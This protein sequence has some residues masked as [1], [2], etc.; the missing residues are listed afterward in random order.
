MQTII[1][2]IT[3]PV[4]LCDASGRLNPEAK[5]WSRHPY[6]IGN[7]KGRPLRK[8]KWDYWCIIGER[9]AFSATMAH[10]DYGGGGAAYLLDFDTKRFAQHTAFR[11]F[12]SVPVM[13]E[14]VGGTI[15]FEHKGLRLCFEAT[16]DRVHMRVNS[17]SLQGQPL[18][19]D[20]I[21]HRPPEHETLNVLV[22]WNDTTFQ[23][24]SKQ[25]C[26]P[27][28]GEVIWG[29]ERYEFQRETAFGV[30][31]YGRGIWPYRT[32][33]NWGAFSARA[34]QDV[35]GINM[36]AKWTD[37]TGMNENGITVNGV[38][39][40]IFDDLIFDY[41]TS[42]FMKPWTIRTAASDMVDLTLAPFYDNVSGANMIILKSK[43][44]QM[45]GRF[46][47]TLKVEG[48]SYPIRDVVGWAEEN[49]ARW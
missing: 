3:Q 31:D 5:G 48:K 2:E 24:T 19:A 17:K 35:V 16:S 27:T 36:G 49:I 42:D 38:L 30:L 14:T 44:H 37:G 13:P 45:F 22:P 1:H 23:F 34:G 9:C 10:I 6:H 7:L 25:N 43:C 12:P 28:E 18:A 8:K 32:A 21:I 11:F 20:L 46:S 33:W 47:G 39:H 29:G 26:L 40:K 15:T 4:N 41:D